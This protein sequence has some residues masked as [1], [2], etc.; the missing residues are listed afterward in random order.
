MNLTEFHNE[1]KISLPKS[2]ALERKKWASII[3]QEQFKIHS[4]ID[5]LKGQKKTA[6]RFQWLLT[7][8]GLL[9]S[10]FLYKELPFLLEQS[11][12][13]NQIDFKVAFATYWSISGIPPQNEAKAIDLLFN[14]LICPIT[15]ITIKSR[16][17]SALLKLTKKYPD[18]EYE[19]KVCMEDQMDKNTNSF[20]LKLEK[21][22]NNKKHE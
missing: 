8:I 21:I 19:L 13:I 22:L 12:E 4:F 15:N 5:L 11:D 17:L 10:S 16:S 14:W 20:Q 7:E 3:I 1:L 6:L 2:T 18:L 9:N